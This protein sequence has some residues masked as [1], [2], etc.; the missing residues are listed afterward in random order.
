MKHREH[1]PE[2]KLIDFYLGNLTDQENNIIKKH[3]CQCDK[4]Q[5]NL[6]QWKPILHKSPNEIPKPNFS[7]KQRIMKNIEDIQKQ[8]ARFKISKPIF[9]YASF[10]F[11]I[12][13]FI[14]INGYK[15]DILLENLTTFQNV[16]RI[17]KDIKQK[18]HTEE[19]SVLPVNNQDSIK[20]QVWV[21]HVTKEMLLQVKGLENL[22]NHDHQLWII[23][24]DNSFDYEILPIVNGET[25]IF[26]EGVNVEEFKELKAS[27]EPKGGSINQTGPE[28]F[29]VDFHR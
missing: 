11:L 16:E 28:I 23:Y 26:I 25:E 17:E 18:R 20:G 13:V 22:I 12:I 19:L 27:I 15:Q 8:R 1:I 10:A 5:M 2:E 29:F 4:C 24:M 9:I 21:N 3:I 14:A 6:K 7:L